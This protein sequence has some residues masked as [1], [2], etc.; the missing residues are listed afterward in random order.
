MKNITFT[1]ILVMA[2]ITSLNCKGGHCDIENEKPLDFS[3]VWTSYQDHIFGYVGENYQRFYFIIDSIKTDAEDSLLY[4]VW[5][6]YR[7]KNEI[8]IMKVWYS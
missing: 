1:L 3:S 8:N 7:I 2:I 6:K 4:E 5:G